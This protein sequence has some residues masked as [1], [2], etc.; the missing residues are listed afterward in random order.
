MYPDTADVTSCI[1]AALTV[2]CIM[3]ALVVS[4]II[5]VDVMSCI[6]A[7]G[8]AS[9]I[10]AGLAAVSCTI[11]EDSTRAAGCEAH[12]SAY[13]DDGVSAIAMLLASAPVAEMTE[14]AIENLI[15]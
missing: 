10:M 6:I 15:L 11:F 14:S 1:T 5:A 8:V 4:C 9:Y 2:S 12:I 7:V 3:A 13:P